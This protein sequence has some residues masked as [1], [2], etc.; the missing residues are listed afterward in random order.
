MVHL[1]TSKGAST[2]S[3]D[4]IHLSP[5]LR[6]GERPSGEVEFL[7]THTSLASR[8]CG[9]GLRIHF[10]WTGKVLRL[11]N[12]GVGYIGPVGPYVWPGRVVRFAPSRLCLSTQ[13]PGSTGPTIVASPSLAGLGL[14]TTARF[15][16]LFPGVGRVVRVRRSDL[17]PGPQG[18]P[19]VPPAREVTAHHFDAG[20]FWNLG[21]MCQQKD[22]EAGGRA[23]RRTESHKPVVTR[24]G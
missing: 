2:K 12:C 5:S 18:F 15:G 24:Y 14:A 10:A 8:C 22:R 11:R 23:M 20:M 9:C 6:S 21:R 3:V 17:C 16:R 19:R 13:G 4:N 1:R 7:L